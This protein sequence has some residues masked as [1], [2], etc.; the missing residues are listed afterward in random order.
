MVPSTASTKRY[1]SPG[2]A[3]ALA[4]PPRQTAAQGPATARVTEVIARG[5]DPDV[6]T[7][8]AMSAAEGIGHARSLVADMRRTVQGLAAQYGETVDI[9]R[10]KDDVA[11][12]A[13]D[14]NLL[15]SAAPRTPGGPAEVVYIP[16]DDYADDFWAEADDEGLGA[17]GRG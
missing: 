9:H 7:A 12:L 17:Q 2:V 13:A 3:L 10:L 16:D 15:A 6:R 14:L 1:G 11:R 5:T 8:G 4:V